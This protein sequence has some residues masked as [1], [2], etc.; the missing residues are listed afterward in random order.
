ME[1]NKKHYC[2][3]YLEAQ[4]GDY[5]QKSPHVFHIY[6]DIYNDIYFIH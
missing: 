1:Q 4:S 3:F 5:C 2:Y 6:N